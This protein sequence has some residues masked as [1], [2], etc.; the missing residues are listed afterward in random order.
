MA[1][2]LLI[3]GRTK[4]IQPKQKYKTAE[5]QAIEDWILSD[6]FSTLELQTAIDKLKNR[7]A[8][9]VDHMCME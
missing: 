1:H 3:N 6:P 2:Q 7:K 8:A 5:K 9:S 4:K